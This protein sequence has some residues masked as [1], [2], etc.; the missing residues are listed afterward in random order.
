MNSIQLIF[1]KV[2]S[3][4]SFIVDVVTLPTMISSLHLIDNKTAS[5]T[6]KCKI[7]Y[8]AFCVQ[9]KF[10]LIQITFFASKLRNKTTSGVSSSLTCDKKKKE[11]D[12]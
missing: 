1:N 8:I 7:T 10:H 9:K 6:A 4:E 12:N 5:F 2:S 11:T 3:K